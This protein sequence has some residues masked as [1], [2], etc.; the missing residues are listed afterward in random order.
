M[1]KLVRFSDYDV[2]GY[3]A[4]GFVLMGICDV[5]IGTN[6]VT[7]VEWTVVHTGFVIIVGYVIGHG[8]AAFS[9]PILD[10]LIVRKLI[11]TPTKLLMQKRRDSRLP[12]WIRIMLG[13]YLTPLP[14][15]VQDRII[16]R[17]GLQPHSAIADNSES[18]F[19]RAWPVIKREP[20]PYG[21]MDSFLRLYG[22]CRSLSVVSLISAVALLFAWVQHPTGA[23]LPSGLGW[24]I[25]I[26]LVI[27]VTMF[28]RYLK[29]FRLYGIEVLSTFAESPK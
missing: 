9:T 8:V 23:K 11:G 5:A 19:Y 26:A 4:P 6:L 21:R 14:A 20:I 1:E 27:S 29:F 18:L 25:V 2:F 10:R 3:L 12:R 17:A 16:E 28:K 22:F 24:W 15:D 13:E 7:G